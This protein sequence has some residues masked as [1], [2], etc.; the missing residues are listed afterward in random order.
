MLA[1]LPVLVG[2]FFAGIVAGGLALFFAA[3]HWHMAILSSPVEEDS[4]PPE[5]SAEE[6][7]ALVAK[8]VS[9]SLR[10]RFTKIDRALDEISATATAGAANTEKALQKISRVDQSIRQLSEV[11]AQISPRMSGS[12]R[13]DEIR[14]RN[15]ES[16]ASRSAE[17]Y[18]TIGIQDA[19]ESADLAT[20]IANN[21][22]N[23][24]I[25]TKRQFGAFRSR[26][27]AVLKGKVHDI[28]QEGGVVLFLENS[29]RGQAWPWP[30]GQIERSWTDFFKLPKGAGYPVVSVIRPAVVEF[31]ENEWRMTSKGAVE[32]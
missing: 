21:F 19:E 12:Q 31:A 9:E 1:S 10:Q 27:M 6:T 20:L 23:I 4:T 32:Q 28:R 24:D 15:K 7:A 14:T 29:K 11:V 17:V 22:Q 2:T 30:N 25:E 26:F 18:P 5:S 16:D 8:L 13:P 3:R